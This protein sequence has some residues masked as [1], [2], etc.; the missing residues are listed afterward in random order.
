MLSKESAEILF[1]LL[2]QAR[3]SPAAKDADKNYVA[4]AK[5]RDELIAIITAEEKKLDE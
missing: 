2:T 3:V 4:L 1:K 5:A